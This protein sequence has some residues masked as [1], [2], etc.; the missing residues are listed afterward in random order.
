GI[1]DRD[2][3]ARIVEGH[4]RE[5]LQRQ[6]RARSRHDADRTPALDAQMQAAVAA[7]A[8]NHTG[9]SSSD[10]IHSTMRS[11]PSPVLTL[12]KTKGRPARM[13][14]ASR[15]ITPRSA[16]TYGARSILLMTSR[17]EERRVGKECRTRVAAE[18]TGKLFATANLDDYRQALK[19][20]GDV[21]SDTYASREFS[22]S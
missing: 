10:W 8:R 9:S 2:D 12:V 3:G 7:D 15:S 4:R 5:H 13:R 11:T 14:R 18:R 20:V 21:S 1:E 19:E 16:P 6:R 22:L 17:S